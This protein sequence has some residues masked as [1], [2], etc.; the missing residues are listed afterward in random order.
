MTHHPRRRFEAPDRAAPR[1]HRA[2]RVAARSRTPGS[3]RA[4]LDGVILVGGA[5]RVPAVRA[6]VKKLFGQ[7]PLADIDPDQVVALGAARAGR[8]RS[9]AKGRRTTSS[10]STSSRSRSASRWAAASSTRSSRA[11]RPSRPAARA[12]YTTQ[13]DR[14]TGFEIHVVQGERELVADSRSLARFT[15]KGIPPMAAGHG[16]ARGH[17]PGRRRRPPHRARRE[18]RPPGVEQTVAVK[19]SYGLDDE[20]VEQMLMDALDHGEE[21]LKRATPRREPRRGAA[22]PRGDAQGARARTPSCSLPGERERIDAAIAALESA[23]ARRRPGAESTTSIE[24]LDAREQGVR[25]A[26]DEPRDRARDRGAQGRRRRRRAR[27]PRATARTTERLAWRS[28]GSKGTARSRSRSGRRSSRRRRRSRPRR[29]TP[30]AACA[31]ARPA[32][33]T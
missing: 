27:G 18:S 32:T 19:P 24:E 10:S 13:E 33:S 29:A 15:L 25:D 11:T 21:D 2:S 26:P 22:H 20:A 9:R 3:S 5:T 8:S 12:T 6:Y 31:P 16:E 23:S 17:L 7:E 28:S 4:Q 30:A 14:Q 1:A